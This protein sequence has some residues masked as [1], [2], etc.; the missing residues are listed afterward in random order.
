MS[1][2][3]STVW[4][5][6]SATMV[7]EIDHGYPYM[8][9]FA[10][11]SSYSQTVGHMTMCFG[12]YYSGTTIYIVLADGHSDSSVMK[13]WSSYNDCTIKLRPY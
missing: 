5:N 10:A 7:N 9:G 4:T 1:F 11:G 3:A 13:I 6:S 8:V 12:Y 2:N